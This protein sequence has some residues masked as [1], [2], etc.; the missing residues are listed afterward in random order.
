VGIARRASGARRHVVRP[1]VLAGSL[2]V[3]CALVGCGGGAP[4]LHP[5]HVLAAGDVSMGAG[6]SG[7]ALVRGTGAAS[8]GDQSGSVLQSVAVAPGVAPW[9]A[10]RVGIAGSNEGGLTYSGR[11]ARLDVRHAFDLGRPTLSIGLGASVVIPD[12]PGVSSERS[13]VYGGG[14]D[15]P[16]LL[17]VHSR[18]DLYALWIGP[19][20]GF[21]LLRGNVS[22]T[23]LLPGTA[24]PGVS[25]DKLD[26]VNARHFFVGGL[27]GVRAG[28]R[29]LHVAFEVAASYHAADGT[30]G[31]LP[32]T[33]IRALSI[34]PAGAL[35]ATF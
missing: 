31:A 21:E 25:S 7:Q 3:A 10:A 9:V 16:I 5:A 28:F 20:A 13:A 1:R 29:H 8:N 33:S 30:F 6:V 27:A 34:T 12:R 11:S 22:E 18:S 14:L 26:D 2:G 17:G 23:S 32:A 24:G 19:R 4:L 15:L 35:I